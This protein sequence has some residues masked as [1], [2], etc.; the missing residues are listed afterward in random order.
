[1]WTNKIVVT[2]GALALI[3]SAHAQTAPAQP[4]AAASPAPAAATGGKFV[5][6]QAEKERLTSELI[7]AS[8]Y[9]S[10]GENIGK[11]AHLI[12]D[13]DNK[14]TGAILS[15]GGLMGLGT[16]AVA[17]PWEMV[18][19][20]TK[21]SKDRVVLPMTGQDLANAPEYRT[22]AQQRVDAE[23]QKAQQEQR[24]R[25][26]QPPAAGAASQ[27]SK[28]AMQPPPPAHCR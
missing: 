6:A 8:V 20:E 10:N 11:I 9:A 22:L 14:L 24:Q 17:V 18:K 16:K 23:S 28:P 15:V 21:D 25:A 27:P 2:L 26:M 12:V 3:G 7:G 4:S 1:M 19:F 13:Q 5:T